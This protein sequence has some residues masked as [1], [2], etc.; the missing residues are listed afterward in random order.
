MQVGGARD[1][2][3]AAAPPS[4]VEG[5]K[6]GQPEAGRQV[7]MERTLVWAAQADVRMSRCACPRPD[8]TD[9]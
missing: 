4:G 6:A 3:P 1:K 8:R 2:L 7:M 5:L 9:W